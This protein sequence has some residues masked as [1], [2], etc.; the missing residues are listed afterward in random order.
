[1]KVN[2]GTCH[3][4]LSTK[5]PIDVHLEGAFIMSSLCEKLL[6]ITIDSDLRFDKHISDLY[7]KVGK[8]INAFCQVIGYTSFEKRWIIMKTFVDSQ[9]SQCPLIWLLYSRTLNN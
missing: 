8:K 5:N 6:G 3:I 4:L 9:F 1:M 2:P 7:D